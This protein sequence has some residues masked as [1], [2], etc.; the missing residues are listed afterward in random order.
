[1]AWLKPK[2][3]DEALKWMEEYRPKIVCGGTDLFVDWHSRKGLVNAEHWLDIQEIS[4]L[5]QI[6]MTEE[7]LSLGAAV[8]ASQ[9]WQDDKLDAFP[10]LR[11]AARIVGGWQVQNRASIGGNVANA[12]PAADMVVPLAAARAVI[13]LSGVNGSRSLPISDFI[14]GPRQTALA[15]DEM[16]TSV[17]VP[18]ECLHVPQIFMRHDQRG[19]T[20]ISIVS[21]AVIAKS[22]GD[23][24]E[25]ARA[26]VGAANAVPVILPEEQEA[27]WQ[28]VM[29]EDKLTRMSELYAASSNPISDVRASAEYRRAMVKVFTARAARQVL[30]LN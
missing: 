12:S 5:K 6:Q 25:W 24:L 17:L 2:S 9:I 21:V 22:S 3:V 23:Q 13:R 11:Q 15:P 7:G 4:E 10:S 29:D 28:G 8:T 19:A 20:D 26:A 18:K 14:L 16:I 27:L 30:G 1:M